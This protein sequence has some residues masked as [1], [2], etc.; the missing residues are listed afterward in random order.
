MRAR[1]HWASGYG[2]FIE[3]HA[4]TKAARGLGITPAAVEEM[5]LSH[6]DG[7]AFD[8]SELREHPG[9][10]GARRVARRHWIFVAGSRYCPACLADD[11]AWRLSWRLPWITCCPH[12]ELRLCWRCPSCGQIPG[13]YGATHA[14]VPQR[15]PPVAD[16]SRCDL[17]TQ[18]GHCCADLTTT[19]PMPAEVQTLATSAR[20][21]AIIGAGKGTFAG[22]TW[23][24]PEVL[25]GYQSAI[26][27]AAHLGIVRSDDWG[28]T[29]RWTS[30]PRD[31]AVLDE[32]LNIV[33][34]VAQAPG[35]GAAADVIGTWCAQAG[36]VPDANTF[37]RSTQVPAAMRR[38]VQQVLLQHGRALTRARRLGEQ[39]VLQLTDW[40][41][42]DVPQVAWPCALSTE[43]RNSTKPN[44]LLLRAVVSLLLAGIVHGGS[45][46]Q[47]GERLGFPPGKGRGWGRYAV[48]RRL[49]L[50]E[51]L[52]T[53]AQDLAP[54]LAL[55]PQRDAWAE[56]PVLSEDVYGLG[57]LVD[58]QRPSC[59]REDTSSVWCPCTASRPS[60]A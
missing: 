36:V 11:G 30:P 31:P 55:Q 22:T 44:A 16:T 33:S 2:I 60:R 17:Y 25:R 15:T 48:S 41:A 26:S 34:P 23:A 8:L 14:S 43:L 3:A 9:L 56:R 47:S 39:G 18:E 12:H 27:L 59:R 19:L 32:L 40:S 45:W 42:A 52:L 49:G 1:G 28:R 38:V 46:E 50:R 24:A 57:C 29:H 37:D 5:Q 53:L 13:V 54:L 51:H 21:A 20:L 4:A 6:Y 58:A 35:P 7:R 10:A